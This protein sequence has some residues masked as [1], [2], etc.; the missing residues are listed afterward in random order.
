[1]DNK[2]V[3]IGAIVNVRGINGELVV[4]DIPKGI[5]KISTPV[6][7]EIG[8]SES[9]TQTFTLNFWKAQGNKGTAKI[10]DYETPEAA[11]IFKEKGIFIQEALLLNESNKDFFENPFQYN[12]VDVNTSQLIGVVIEVWELP[13]NQVFLVKTEKGDLPIPNA[14]DSVI[15]IDHNLKVI[16]VNLLPGIWEL[17]IE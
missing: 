3:Y 10:A 5:K 15:S 9:F 11:A 12:V 13:A 7:I 4:Q 6:E 14:P 17:I 2:L 1:V 16:N 8:F